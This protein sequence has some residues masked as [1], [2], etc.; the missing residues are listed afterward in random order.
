MVDEA[1]KALE[2]ARSI[3]ARCDAFE[4][5]LVTGLS[6]AIETFLNG[7]AREQQHELL[8]ELLGLEFDFR[9]A[10][11]EQISV[12]DYAARFPSLT[13][14]QIERIL[15]TSDSEAPDEPKPA[16][17]L[18]SASLQPTFLGPTDGVEDQ[19]T[20]AAKTPKRV[21]YFGDYELLREVARGGMGVVYEARQRSLNRPVALKMILSGQLASSEEIARFRREAEAAAKLEHPG[22]VPIFEI[23]TDGDQHYFTMGYVSGPSLSARLLE[24]PLAPNE[25]ASL[26]REVAL[27]VQYAH[28]RGVVHRDLKPSNILLAPRSDASTGEL[29]Y[30]PRVTDFGLANITQAEHSL[31][32]TGQILGTPSYM[33]PEQAAGQTREIGPPSDVYSLGAV[34]YACLTGRPPF[35]SASALDTVR[36]V[37]ERDPVSLRDLNAAIPRDLETIC[38]KCLEKS[39]PRRYST[40]QAVADELQRYLDGRPIEARPVSRRE[41]FRRWCLRN[42]VIAGLCTAVAM[43][44]LLGIVVSS[45]FAWKESQRAVAEA[46]ARFDEARQRKEADR[47]A[48]IASQLAVEN[49]KLANDEQAAR[50]KADLNADDALRQANLAKRHL[51]A[52]QMNLVQAAWD[53]ARVGEARRLLDIYRPAPGQPPEADDPRG[54][55]WYY[56][57]R[58]CHAALRTI[59]P[60]PSYSVAF[61]PDGKRLV[62]GGVGRTPV[63]VWEVS[64]GREMLA[65]RGHLAPLPEFEPSNAAQIRFEELKQA[66]G[67]AV[68]HSVACSPDGSRIASASDDGTVKVWDAVTGQELLTLRG[69]SH[70]VGCVAFSPDGKRLASSMTRPLVK[71]RPWEIKLWDATS[72]QEL[73]SL[74]GQDGGTSC[75]TFSTDGKRFASSG[76][77]STTIVWDAE[78]TEQLLTFHGASGC[79]AFSPNGQHLAAAGAGGVIKIWDA[80]T[81]AETHTLSVHR[82][83]VTS[84]SFSS[85]SLRLASASIDQTIRVWDVQAGQ[86]ALTLKGHTESVYGVAY[87]PD[88]KQIASASLDGTVKIWD[89]TT[90]Q[91][92]STS[93]GMSSYVVSLSFSG[94]G[95]QLAVAD[96]F[97]VYLCNPA[98]AAVARVLKSDA[99]QTLSRK[100][101]ISCVTMNPDGK[102]IALGVDT[103]VKVLDTATGAEIQSLQGHSGKVTCV[104][105]SRD[106]RLASLGGSGD[107]TIKLWNVATGQVIQ[108]LKGVSPNVECVAFNPDGQALASIGDDKSVRLWDCATGKLLLTLDGCHAVHSVSFSPDSRRIA[109]ACTDKTVRIW[110]V[111]TGMEAASLKG[112]FENVTGTAFSPD[113]KRVATSSS[114]GTLR[115]WDAATGMV[116]IVFKGYAKQFQDVAFSPDGTR[117]SAG[118][119]NGAIIWDATPRHPIG[120]DVTP[121]EPTGRPEITQATETI[122]RQR[123]AEGDKYREQKDYAQAIDSYREIIKLQPDNAQILNR[124]A[125]VLTV[126]PLIDQAPGESLTLAQRASRQ[127]PSNLN[128]LNSLGAAQFRAGDISEALATL[129]EVDKSAAPNFSWRPHN[130]LFQALCHEKRGDVAKAQAA[131]NRALSFLKQEHDRKSR[132]HEANLLVKEVNAVMTPSA[133]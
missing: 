131:Y 100:T 27:A 132:W 29:S 83:H 50:H 113:G 5:A 109:A 31:T 49:Q 68:V 87:C 116:V 2:A 18:G 53:A 89:A 12:K 81:A 84:L 91:D 88:G 32:E 85:D 112:H 14:E 40:A 48:M 65:F 118:S 94:D 71:N 51:Y 78:T 106:G 34:L 57:D 17:E 61:S 117:L 120:K 77:N 55:E 28:D 21:R 41:R 33:P 92:A 99:T 15:R 44:L 86:V 97:Q 43:S 101:W 42:P 125:W 104:A 6:P 90:R 26:I 7:I 114:D 74:Q 70:W 4:K 16:S 110:D 80:N 60:T 38:L 47:Q 8:E 67:I 107:G 119:S 37:L 3:D 10:R 79:M 30:S 54:F 56:W 36:Q 96:S 52:A 108:T 9:R 24:R 129:M 102:Y 105:F 39:I 123:R 127:E 46:D 45:Y 121:G 1:S 130:L 23:G 124:L 11:G 122:V 126:N 98:T 66:Y 82:D 22:I 20:T 128:Y 93:A 25:A 95:K 58:C 13:N 115:V 111:A 73:H 63:K 72:G 35:Q 75:V 69:H 76:P 103:T 64:S 133:E 62:T 19:A 59:V